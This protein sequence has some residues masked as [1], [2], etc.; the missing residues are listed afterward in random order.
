M[1]CERLFDS[2]GGSSEIVTSRARSAS[3]AARQLLVDL[4]LQAHRQR[5]RA[6]L[7]GL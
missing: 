1:R 5:D 3:P 7:V 6:A 4:E 2:A